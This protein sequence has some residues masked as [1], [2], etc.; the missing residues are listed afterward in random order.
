[1]PKMVFHYSH[2]FS[3][4]KHTKLIY[5][6][7]FFGYLSLPPSSKTEAIPKYLRKIAQKIRVV[8]WY[9]PISTFQRKSQRFYI[10]W[11]VPLAW[12]YNGTFKSKPIPKD[13]LKFFK[14]NH[15]TVEYVYIAKHLFAG[16]GVR[17][18]STLWLFSGIHIFQLDILVVMINKL[19]VLL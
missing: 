17:W 10:K 4:E 12:T 19:I 3:W 2:R 1:M 14:Y 15:F 16:G 18:S 9:V 8:W 13:L 7:L 5:M 6:L 11:N